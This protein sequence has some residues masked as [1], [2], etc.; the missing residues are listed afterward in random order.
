M[1]QPRLLVP[2]QRAREIYLYLISEPFGLFKIGIAA[3]VEQRLSTLQAAT[4][5]DLTIVA[6]MRV[7]HATRIESFI[8]DLLAKHRVRGEWFRLPEGEKTWR[9]AVRQ[10]RASLK[11]PRTLRSL[12]PAPADPFAKYSPEIQ[13]ELKRRAADPN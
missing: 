2:A 10:Y 11:A 6:K 4:P 1:S 8:H 13:S 12:V 9:D 3:D 5:Y 7:A